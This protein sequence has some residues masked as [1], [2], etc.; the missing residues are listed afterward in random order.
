M[1]SLL[2]S[3]APRGGVPFRVASAPR[4]ALPLAAARPSAY[5][6]AAPSLLVPRPGLLSASSSSFLGGEPMLLPLV[7]RRAR[8]SR[9]VVVDAIA[10][11]HRWQPGV[12]PDAC[13]RAL[14]PWGVGRGGKQQ[15]E[16]R[17]HVPRLSQASII[18][19]CQ[20]PRAMPYLGPQLVVSY[21][22]NAIGGAGRQSASL[23]TQLAWPPRTGATC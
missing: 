5:R 4:A 16:H 14:P 20:G 8:H 22:L 13:R 23:A 9:R 1:Q 3:C 11:A 6:M 2:R 19:M 18:M 21:V 17:L 15:E 10:C 7:T 12:A